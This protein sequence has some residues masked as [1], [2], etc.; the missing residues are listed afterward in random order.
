RER[1][2]TVFVLEDVHWAGEATL[3][4]LRLLARGVETVPALIVS[5]YRDDGLDRAH[6]LRIVLGE[7]ATGRTVAR[8]KLAALS[9][10]A[11]AALAEPPGGAADLARLAHHAEAGGD[12]NAVLRFAP[13]AAARAASLGAHREAAAQ[14]ARALRFGDRLPAA[15]R[16]GLL[17]RRAHECLLTD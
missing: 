11:V 9:A 8:L 17:E 16:A 15:E 1:A 12:A 3:D 5:S 14:Y 2:P 10:A 7:L 6:P 4:V 13:A